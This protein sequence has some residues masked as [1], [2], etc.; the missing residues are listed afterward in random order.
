[1]EL[2]LQGKYFHSNSKIKGMWE[3]NAQ[4]HGVTKITILMQH[5]YNTIDE[6]KEISSRVDLVTVLQTV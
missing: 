4:C 1:M 3:S 2:H 5:K 6:P